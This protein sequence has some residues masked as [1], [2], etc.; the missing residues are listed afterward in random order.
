MSKIKLDIISQEKPILSAEV[1]QLT[2]PAESGEV[3]ILPNHIPLFTKLKDGIITI[4]NGNRVDELAVLGGF[5]DV[6][7]DSKITVLAD[8]AVRADDINIAKAEAAKKLAEEA[9]KNKGS[10]IEFKEAEASLR[11][12]MLELKAA[13]RLKQRPQLPPQE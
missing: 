10:E 5:M 6:G 4:K 3:T 2:A 9:I 7:P 11:R 1:D 12:A 8:A 13:N